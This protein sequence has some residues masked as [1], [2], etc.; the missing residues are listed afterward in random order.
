M[1]RARRFNKNRCQFN[2]SEDEVRRSGEPVEVCGKPAT[3]VMEFRR[4]D[5]GEDSVYP[6]CEEHIGPE[7]KK[8]EHMDPDIMDIEEFNLIAKEEDRRSSGDIHI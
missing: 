6:L 2:I 8:Y 5:Q 4:S 1:D 3:H 7:A